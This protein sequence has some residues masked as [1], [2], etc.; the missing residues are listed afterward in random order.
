MT[1]P[2]LLAAK[3]NMKRNSLQSME[4]NITE[5][6]AK[7][8]ELEA[9]IEGI[10]SEEDLTVIESQVDENEKAIEDAEN[11]KHSLEEEIA[12]LEGELERSNQKKPT[13]RS[14]GVA[15]MPKEI[16]AREAINQ[17]VRSKGVIQER[18]GF[19][20]VEGGALIPVELLAPTKELTD[21]V[22][23]LP[24]V[25]NVKVNSSGGK[26]PVIKKSGTKMATVA[27]LVA[28]PELAKPTI[29]EV[30]YEIDT[31]RGYIPVSQE[32]IDDADYDITGLIAEEIADQELNTRNAAIATILK[33]ATAKTISSIDALIT[34]LNIDFKQVYNVKLYVSRSFFNVLDLAKDGDGTYLLSPDVT[35]ASGKRFKGKEVIVLDDEIIGT[36]ADD[37]VA[38]IGDAKEFVTFF[39]RNQASVKWT[40]NNVYGQLLAGYVRF[41]VKAVDTAAGYYVTYDETP[42]P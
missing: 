4:A 37:K 8:S 27:E 15:N 18:A 22:D 11:E 24:Y 41:D 29:T 13:N 14:K 19:T 12:E 3:A 38:F 40:D 17:Y 32:V 9:A 23:L 6:L 10:E 30:S 39:N 31:Y 2:V 1:S 16:E 26:Y 20:S 34:H 33:T 25:R 5:L 7:R 21:S 28:N 35:V 36:T 42:T